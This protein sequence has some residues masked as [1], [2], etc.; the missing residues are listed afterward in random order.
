MSLAVFDTEASF[1]V[2]EAEVGDATP[3]VVTTKLADLPPGEIEIELGTTANLLVEI[4][5][6]VFPPADARPFR[7]SVP[8]ATLPP[9]TDEGV[10]VNIEREGAKIFKVATL[11]FPPP[12][13]VILTSCVLGTPAVPI[14]NLA[15]IDPAGTATVEG[16][17]AKP[18]LEARVTVNPPVGAFLD[19]V[20][21]PELEFPP[22]TV[23]GEH[24]TPV[25]D[26]P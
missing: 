20:T 18:E 7:L 10:M 14:V 15:L 12:E 22:T 23:D 13:A 11:D 3:K 25:T 21:C 24:P 6:I 8:K 17:I 26:C 1:A 5:V 16:T 4:S 19:I 2:I 9:I